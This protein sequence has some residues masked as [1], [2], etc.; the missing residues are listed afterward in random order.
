MDFVKRKHEFDVLANKI[1]QLQLELNTAKDDNDY[2]RDLL[3]KTRLRIL[4][5]KNIAGAA[6]KVP[7]SETVN[8]AWER[9]IQAIID[10]LKGSK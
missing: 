5:I 8:A 9:T 7:D 3:H 1:Q 4:D 10:K 6:S 2:Y